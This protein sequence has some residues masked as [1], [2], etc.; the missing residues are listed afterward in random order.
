MSSLS[1]NGKSQGVQAQAPEDQAYRVQIITA[2]CLLVIVVFAGL[3]G[4]VKKCLLS[5]PTTKGD[6][7]KRP[8]NFICCSK[9]MMPRRLYCR[10]GLA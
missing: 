6:C 7:E 3:K 9:L 4:F 5:K 1:S 8:E 2:V 10:L